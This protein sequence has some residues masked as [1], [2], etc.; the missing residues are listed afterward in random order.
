MQQDQTPIGVF[1]AVAVT[2]F[3]PLYAPAA[4]TY[5]VIAFGSFAGFLIWLYRRAPGPRMPAFAYGFVVFTTAFF[6]TVSVATK[7]GGSDSSWLYFPVSMFIAACGELWMAWAAATAKRLAK[8][9]LGVSD[10]HSK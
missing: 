2:L 4:T 1:M 8:K 7:I 5:T 9:F 3:G 10:E 6:M